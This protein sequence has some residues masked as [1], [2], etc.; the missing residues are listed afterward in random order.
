MSVR[1]NFLKLYKADLLQVWWQPNPT[2]SPLN[3][4]QEQKIIDVSGNLTNPSFLP[5]P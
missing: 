5:R 4:R 1:G 2:P 3:D